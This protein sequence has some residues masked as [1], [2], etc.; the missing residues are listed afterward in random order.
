MCT[1]HL[2]SDYKPAAW[3]ELRQT[4]HVWYWDVGSNSERLLEQRFR[5][6]FSEAEIAS[7]KQLRGDRLRKIRFAAKVLRNLTL[8]H[9]TAV[10]PADWRFAPGK[11]GKPEVAEPSAFASLRFNLTHTDGL[12]ACIISRAREVGVD[13]EE[14]SREVDVAEVTPHFFSAA[15]QARIANSR[16]E[17]RAARFFEQWV[18]KETYFKA[19]GTGIPESPARISLGWTEDDQPLSLSDWQFGLKWITEGHVAA[20]AVQRALDEPPTPIHWFDAQSLAEC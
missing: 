8:S 2:M 13:A 1:A 18:V 17:R 3:D 5:H 20:A 12:V 7:I 16:P 15:E 19:C 10:P 9:Y 4:A 11:H 14:S 6:W